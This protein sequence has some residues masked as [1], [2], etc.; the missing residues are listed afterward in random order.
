M[1][2]RS[3]QKGF[4]PW[5]FNNDTATPASKWL[6]QFHLGA[7]SYPKLMA[8]LLHYGSMI[9]AKAGPTVEK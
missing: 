1:D 5:H 7:I 4:K 9:K 6:N 2:R 3:Y 8:R